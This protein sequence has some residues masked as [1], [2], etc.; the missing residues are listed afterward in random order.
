MS[1][2]PS[3]LSPSVASTSNRPSSSRSTQMSVVPPP[4]SNVRIW[5]HTR[6][7]EDQVCQE[8]EMRHERPD[9]HHLLARD[10]EPVGHGGGEGLGQQHHTL[11]PRK[12]RRGPRGTLLRLGSRDNTRQGW[13]PSGPG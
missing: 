2:P 7:A 9:A 3:S 4:M 8:G 6:A 11:E 12:L 5:A 13:G 10:K 1:S